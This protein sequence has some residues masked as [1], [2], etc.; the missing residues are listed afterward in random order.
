MRPKQRA[1]D[2]SDWRAIANLGELLINAASLK[3]Q[4]DRII[5]L[6]AQMVRGN[7]DVWLHED[8]FRMPD[9]KEPRSFPRRPRSAAML[10][11][12]LGRKTHTQ[13]PP[14]GSTSRKTVV[15][16][17]I[18]DQGLVLGVLQVTRPSGPAFEKSELALL[19]SIAG[20]V[21]VG[22]YASLRVEVEHFR[23][24]ELNLVR[25]VSAQIATVLQ[26]DELARRVCELI[27]ETFNY[28]YV[29]IFTLKPGER[30]L[31]FRSSAGSRRTEIRNVPLA[32][33]VEVGQGLI[34]SAAASGLVMNVPDVRADPRYRFTDL[35]P[36]TRSEV[37]IP[38]M[39]N[40]R[41]LGV[42]DVQSNRQGAFHPN[43]LLVLE[44]LADNIARAVEGARLYSD[45][46]RRADQLTF[47]SDVSR[48]VASTLDL[49]SNMEESARLVQ[50]RFGY[51]Y[52]SLFTVHPNRRLIEFE[53]GSGVR[54]PALRGYSIP[55]QDELGIIPWVAREGKTLLANDVSS[56]PLYRLSPVQPKNTKSEL[57]VPLVFGDRVLGVLDIQSERRNAFTEDD[58][59]MFEAVAGTIAASIRNADLYRTEQWRRRVADSL[60]EVAGLLSKHIGVDE[61]LQALLIEL[62]RNLPV[63][64]SVIWLIDQRGFYVAAVHGADAEAIEQ[65]RNSSPEVKSIADELMQSGSAI[66]RQPSDPLWPTGKAAGFSRDYSSL[67]VPMRVGDRPIGLLALAHREPGR[68]GHEA[69][70]MAETFASYAAVAIENSRLYDATQEQAYASAALLQVAQVVASPAALDEVLGTILRTMPILLGVSS[71]ALYGW[72]AT[73]R[74]HV[75]H[76]EF[77][78]S[79]A[80][81]AEVW[82]REFSEGQFRLLDEASILGEATGCALDRSEGP[83]SWTTLIPARHPDRGLTQGRRL[84][85]AVPVVVKNEAL[86][87][88]LVEEGEDASKFR[89]RRL[90]II[91]GIS[92]QIAMAM[93]NDLLENEKVVRE[94]L[95]TEAQLARQIQRTFISHE[96]PKVDGWELAALWETARYVGGDFY[97]AAELTNG[98]L[99]LFIADVA[100]KGMPAALFMALTRTLFRAA[101]SESDSP[102]HVLGRMNEL[103]VPDTGQ[104]MFVT[105]VYAVLDPSSGELTYANAGHN[106]PLWIR[107]QGTIE[108]LGR[109]MIA[110]GIPDAPAASQRTIQLRH[111]ESVLMYTD[112][113]TE[114]FSPSGETFGEHRLLETVAGPPP[115]AES[116]IAV[117]Q[118][119]LRDFV[120]SDERSD[121]LTMLAIRRR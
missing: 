63:E 115:S 51:Q 12:F 69:S 23:L 81:R 77:G 18:E 56:E 110:L 108:K 95:E 52:V 44:A 119:R 118:S 46:R 111:G 87:V 9:W 30:R 47:L 58:R 62:E 59:L 14:H 68:Y 92:Q 82:D 57:A 5:G 20:V 83:Q 117:I 97:D 28:Y 17:P 3:A 93:Q 86:G 105:A 75:P 103:L 45:L 34:G 35:L 104:G 116:I 19:E 40:D 114:A 90:E 109:T 64:V 32:F 41:V 89:A 42:L 99:G 1:T 65:T 91:Q 121:D 71:A 26:L 21:A 22:L 36:A 79:P 8:L 100:D 43:D 13:R 7:V 94:R 24:G 27:Q 6:T 67:V 49:K 101:V 88:L 54:S 98:R 55:L 10:R 39:L 2:F 84:L 78:L 33:E 61:A 76:A 102:S 107:D 74:C 11:A 38:L 25:Q 15:A 120:G 106:P 113:L 48:R 4:R 37:A 85:I 60:R 70:G 96:L 72:D 29:A 53:A 16:M 31:R 66:I 73:R 112:G 80:A 50:E